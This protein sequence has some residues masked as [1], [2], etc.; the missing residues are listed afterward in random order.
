MTWS[1][2]TTAGAVTTVTNTA[3]APLWVRVLVNSNTNPAYVRATVTQTG[4]VPF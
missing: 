3:Y 2:F 1:T 4:V